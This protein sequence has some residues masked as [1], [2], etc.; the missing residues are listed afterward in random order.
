MK[1]RN[2]CACSPKTGEE[3][4]FS[5]M[6]QDDGLLAAYVGWRKFAKV[7]NPGLGLLQ[8][9]SGVADGVVV[10]DSQKAVGNAM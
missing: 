2:G 8:G 1:R 3:R 7:G 10:G 6:V 5:S 4:V 9:S